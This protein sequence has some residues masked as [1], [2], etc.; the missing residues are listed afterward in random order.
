MGAVDFISKPF[1]SA[2]VLARVNTH[3][4][5]RRMAE[6]LRRNTSTDLVTGVASRSQ[7]DDLLEKE[8]LRGLRGGKPIALLLLDVDE[9]KSYGEQVGHIK[10]DACLRHVASALL[11]SGS[12]PADFVARCGGEEFAMLLPETD[13]HGAEHVARRVL[14][15]VAELGI[16]RNSD[17]KAG[18]VSVSIGVASYDEYS[19]SWANRSADE[20][21]GLNLQLRGMGADLVFAAAR[22][23]SLAKR[24]GRGQ[25]RLLDICDVGNSVRAGG[26]ALSR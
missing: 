26:A 13:R 23:L 15:A 20:H 6:T 22:A 25:V 4:R 19:A 5:L 18:H 24:A 8:W 14:G 17:V 1:R 11:S 3:L 7:F 12:R 16:H 21:P 9:F 10:A 2:L